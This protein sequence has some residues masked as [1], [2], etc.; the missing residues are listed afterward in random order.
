MLNSTSAKLYFQ[1][2]NTIMHF[3]LI[4]EMYVY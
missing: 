2:K 4:F 1:I 3:N